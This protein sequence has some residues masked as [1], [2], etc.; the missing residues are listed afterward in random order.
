MDT[1]T[2]FETIQA[3][4]AFTAVKASI[5]SLTAAPV[6]RQAT[7]KVPGESRQARPIALPASA[8]SRKAA[9]PSVNNA[10]A[11]NAPN[12]NESAEDKMRFLQEQLAFLKA[13]MEALAAMKSGTSSHNPIQHF[14]SWQLLYVHIVF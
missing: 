14:F 2:S 13:Q 6:T 12:Q 1:K 9:A 8:A 5:S 11:N 7:F 3:S 10:A 4:S